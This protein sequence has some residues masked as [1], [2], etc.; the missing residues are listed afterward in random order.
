MGLVRGV[1]EFL[2]FRQHLSALF[3]DLSSNPE[4]GHGLVKASETTGWEV[5]IGQEG[6]I[7]PV[8]NGRKEIESGNSKQDGRKGLQV[9]FECAIQH[10]HGA[11][12]FMVLRGNGF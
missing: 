3:I 4:R 6:N 8:S 7:M 5:H 9:E 1:G 2:P 10:H 11:L 12:K